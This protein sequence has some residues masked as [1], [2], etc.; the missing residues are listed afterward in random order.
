[1]PRRKPLQR[2]L[3]IRRNV[4]EKVRYWREKRGLSKP[5]LAEKL[6][7]GTARTTIARLEGIGVGQD[8]EVPAAI[9]LEL[10][11]RLATALDVDAEEFLEPILR[12]PAKRRTAE[13]ATLR[14]TAERLLEEFGDRVTSDAACLKAI[15]AIGSIPDAKERQTIAD[16]ID[17]LAWERG[18]R[19]EAYGPFLRLARATASEDRLAVVSSSNVGGLEPRPASAATVVHQ[20]ST[21]CPRCGAILP[22]DRVLACDGGQHE[23]YL[24]LEQGARHGFIEPDGHVVLDDGFVP[25]DKVRL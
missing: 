20:P 13:E 1:M 12:T 22:V 25:A 18:H 5:Q 23:I 19:Q 2:D 21:R 6:G 8:K 15:N 4:A 24:F 16:M 17:A 14:S 3:E 11:E 9:T 7:A 10:V